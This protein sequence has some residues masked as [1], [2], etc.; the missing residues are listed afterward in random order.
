M[1]ARAFELE[2]TLQRTCTLFSCYSICYVLADER[3]ALAFWGA[4]VQLVQLLRRPLLHSLHPQPH[5]HLHR[6]VCQGSCWVLSCVLLLRP[7]F[8][9]FEFVRPLRTVYAAARSAA[10]F[11]RTRCCSAQVDQTI[12]AEITY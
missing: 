3:R 1:N 6:Q 12:A 9:C 8:V 4:L 2:Y 10:L 11:Q 5:R 7:V